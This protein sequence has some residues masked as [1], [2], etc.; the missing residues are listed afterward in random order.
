MAG[1]FD[2]VVIRR[3][4]LWALADT[5]DYALQEDVRAGFDLYPAHG[6]LDDGKGSWQTLTLLDNGHGGRARCY[7]HRGP[8]PLGIEAP[9]IVAGY[10]GN[11]RRG[12]RDGCN[13]EGL[14][15]PTYPTS[16]DWRRT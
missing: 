12:R 13:G 3:G 16:A 10:A 9:R 7:G 14:I 8:Q 5:I 15:W 11:A 4:H 2:V 1:D 6:E